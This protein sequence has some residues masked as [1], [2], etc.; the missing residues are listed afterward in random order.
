MLHCA[1][2]LGRPMGACTL[3]RSSEWQTGVSQAIWYILNSF[4]GHLRVVQESL[5]KLQIPVLP[6][7]LLHSWKL[8][9]EQWPRLLH[10]TRLPA[11]VFQE[12]TKVF[13]TPT[14]VLV[15]QSV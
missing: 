2:R 15:N 11:Q 4:G 3:E 5:K 7:L 12:G 14:E 8:R 13:Q 10:R 6:T 9:K 1:K